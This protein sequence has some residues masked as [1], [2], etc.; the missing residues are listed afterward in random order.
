MRRRTRQPAAPTLSGASGSSGWAQ[1]G[2]END[3][4]LVP[5]PVPSTGHTVTLADSADSLPRTDQLTPDPSKGAN[6]D[7][8]SL[9]QVDCTEP[10]V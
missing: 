3:T 5:A 6:T 2:R 8:I 1:V 4:F 9:R 7:A 10:G